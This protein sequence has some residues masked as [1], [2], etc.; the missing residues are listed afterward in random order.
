LNFDKYSQFLKS[1][2]HG[3]PIFLQNSFLQKEGDIPKWIFNWIWCTTC[4][5]SYPKNLGW[6]TISLCR[7]NLYILIHKSQNGVCGVWGLKSYEFGILLM[8]LMS[9][10]CHCLLCSMPTNT[11]YY[12]MVSIIHLSL[13]GWALSHSTILTWNQSH[14]RWEHRI[15][16]LTESGSIK[17][18]FCPLAL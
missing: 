14:C 15:C 9:L 2:L 1:T 7:S 18:E 3:H 11:M 4:L 5:P 16:W 10:S 17:A 6:R 8:W 13:A 12:W